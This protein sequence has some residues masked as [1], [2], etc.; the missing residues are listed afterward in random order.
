[1]I[2]IAFR[3]DGGYE[4]GMGHIMRS[5]ALAQAFPQDINISFI[6]KEEESVIKLLEEY[7]F[8]II[9][10]ESNLT[11]KEEINKVQELIKNKQI[12]IL[13]TDSYQIRQDYLIEMKRIV[14]KLV[15]IHDFAPFA[16]PSDIVINGNVY[17][18][19]LDYKS[20]HGNMQFLLGT[21]YTLMREEFQDL[22]KRE[23]NEEVENILVTVGGS[24]LLN[25]TPKIIK[26]LDE[27]DEE[28]HIDIVIGSAFK[29]IDEIITEVRNSNLEINLHFNVRKMSKLM[30]K[31]D[32]A[33]S[34]GGSTLYELAVTGTPAITLL[35][36]DNQILV[37]EAMEEAGVIINLGFG[38]EASIELLRNNIY[39][40]FNNFKFRR[41]LIRKGQTIVNGQ[42]VIRCVEIIMK[43]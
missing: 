29:N 39:K 33:I 35:Q 16:F 36:A 38:N 23:V 21:D 11:Y 5:L 41:Q 26:A 18:P 22:P 25:L 24:D 19:K 30:L 43:Q 3:V 9:T 6:I 8:E 27:L 14:D 4:I 17:A 15:T 34:S 1:M 37:A 28:P 10:I 2:N 40:L 12:D 7:S 20:T 31:G 32:L 42:G 13:I